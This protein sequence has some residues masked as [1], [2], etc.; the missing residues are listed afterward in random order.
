[1]APV[2]SLYSGF[3]VADVVPL[4]ALPPASSACRGPVEPGADA[5][6]LMKTVSIEETTADMSSA[7]R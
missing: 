5:A 3:A 1:M 6:A 2:S 7:S 4:P